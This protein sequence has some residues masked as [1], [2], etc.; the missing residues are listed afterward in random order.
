MT[1]LAIRLKLKLVMI[2]YHPLRHL[3]NLKMED[4]KASP[5]DKST[6]KL[7]HTNDLHNKQCHPTVL[8]FRTASNRLGEYLHRP[9]HFP[10]SP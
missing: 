10:N 1:S 7:K 8:V 9:A 5:M 2:H 3:R 6:T 4:R